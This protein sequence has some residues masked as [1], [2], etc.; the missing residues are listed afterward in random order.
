MR[1]TRRSNAGCAMQRRR[2]LTHAAPR[3]AETIFGLSGMV[4]AHYSG[5][6]L[7]PA[8]EATRVRYP[9]LNGG[10]R[11][12]PAREHTHSVRIGRIASAPPLGSTRRSCGRST[13]SRRQ[14]MS[15][16]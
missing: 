3:N 7:V 5:P 11:S 4:A 13:L 1:C 6:A 10:F 15:V 12:S 14:T 16:F 9:P 2:A 8:S